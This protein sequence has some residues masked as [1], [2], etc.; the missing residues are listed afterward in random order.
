MADKEKYSV[1][2]GAFAPCADRFVT[3]GYHKELSLE[4]MIQKVAS[5]EGATGLELDYPFMYPDISQFKG[6]IK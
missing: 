1:S 3:C 4:Q 2:L 5:V 6:P